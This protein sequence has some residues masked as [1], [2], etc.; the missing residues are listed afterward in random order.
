MA[1]LNGLYSASVLDNRDP[2]NLARVFVRVAGLTRRRSDLWAR[3][4]T[5]MA[6]RDSGTVFIPE[7]GDEVL[8]AFE[9]EDL[10][11]PYVL[12]ALWNGQDKPP[13]AITVSSSP[14][15]LMRA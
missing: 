2:E 13:L 7:V 14:R 10:R 3:L 11:F 8:V 12:G 9:R 1:T 4:G 6:G 15:E 5:V